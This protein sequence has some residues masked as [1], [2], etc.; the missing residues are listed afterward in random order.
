MEKKMKVSSSGVEF[1]KH[2]I[3]GG[4]GSADT[5]NIPTYTQSSS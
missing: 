5:Q 1:E 4:G 3:V 2:L